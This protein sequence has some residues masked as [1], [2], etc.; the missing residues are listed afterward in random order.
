VLSLR[1]IAKNMRLRAKGAASFSQRSLE[2]F[3]KPELSLLLKGANNPAKRS[4]DA[5]RNRP[6]GV[7][8]ITAQPQPR[9]RC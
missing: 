1:F 6:V 3:I 2:E 9:S 4:A 7:M 5:S 8:W